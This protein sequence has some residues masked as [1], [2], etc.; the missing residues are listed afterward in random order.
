MM[1]YLRYSVVA[2]LL[3]ILA[4]PTTAQQYNAQTLSDV[5]NQ[6]DV[7]ECSHIKQQMLLKK[8]NGKQSFAGQNI[9]ITYTRMMWNINPAVKFISGVVTPYFTTLEPLHQI[10]L[11]KDTNL[12]VDSIIFHNQSISFA[13]SADYLMNIYFPTTLALGATDSVSIYYHGIPSASGFGSFVQDIHAGVPII[14]TL[15]EPYGAR[16]WWPCK[17]DLSDKIDSIDV[18]VSCPNGNRAASNG[19]LVKEIHG[20]TTSLYHWKHRYPIATYLVAFAVT[21]YTHYSDYASIASGTVE[22]L[23]YVYPEDSAYAKSHTPNV[24]SSIQLYSQLFIDYPFIDEKY[25]H[26][27]FGW[28]GGMEHQTMSFMGGFS[29]PLMAHEL[30]HQWFGDMVTCGSWQ[31]IWLNEGFATYLTGLTYEAAPSLPYWENW[32]RQT[33]N[34]VMSQP[35]GSVFCDDTTSVGRIFDSRLSY[36][37]GAYVLHMLRWV[38]GDSAFFAGIRNYLNDT[39]LSYGYAYTSDLKQHLETSSGLNLTG[40]FDDWYYGQGFPTYDITA[41]QT[42]ATNLEIKLDQTQSHTS[43]SFFEMPLPIKVYFSDG[44]DTTYVLNNTSSGQ[45]F[46]LTTKDYPDS[47]SIDP[48]RHIV[49]MH[50]IISSNVGI[51]S[52]NKNKDFLIYPNPTNNLVNINSNNQAILEIEILDIQGRIL[53]KIYPKGKGK[54]IEINLSKYVTGNYFLRIKTHESTYIRNI[55]KQ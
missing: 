54:I 26:A 11:E 48:D 44:T 23:N 3:L 27:Q 30:A 13:D 40:F 21:N 25:G 33:M 43:V 37:K 45:L 52:N 50:N 41:N 38:C 6:R 5:L 49:C 9:N 1:N 4:Q 14:W 47:I 29:H 34:Q 22:V 12:I 31:D 20:P 24:I 51:K 19:V 32:K 18:Y 15:S 36:S 16:E 55:L 39:N 10:S 8:L 46:Q 35:G 42:S 2:F 7:K 28:G 17:N 53:E